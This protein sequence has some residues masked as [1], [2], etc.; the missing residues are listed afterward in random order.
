MKKILTAVAALILAASLSYAAQE[1]TVKATEPAGAVVE[2]TGVLIGKVTN[3]I[4]KSLGGGKTEGSLVMADDTGKTKIIPLDSTVKVLD[5][6]FHALTLNQL[7]GRKV[8]VAVSG[9]K[10]TTV[11]EVQ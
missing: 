2:T 5:T 6:T 3:V 11:Q 4:E 7:K 1:P 10:G 8:S 9:G